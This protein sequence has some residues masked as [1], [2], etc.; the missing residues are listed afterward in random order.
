MDDFEKALTAA[1]NDSEFLTG[2]DRFASGARWAREWFDNKFEFV[3]DQAAVIGKLRA[4]NAKLR[5]ALE[6]CEKNAGDV[7][8]IGAI[9]DDALNQPEWVYSQAFKDRG[10]N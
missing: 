2:D 5:E 10:N 1:W 6:K 3:K 8:M 4:E 9:V 7:N